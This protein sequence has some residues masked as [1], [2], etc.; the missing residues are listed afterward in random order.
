RCQVSVR[1]E[2]NMRIGV[3]TKSFAPDFELCT[4]LNRSVLVNSPDTVQHHII[5]PRSDL[6]LFS[7]LSSPRTHIRCEVD[8]LPRTFV[9]VPFI[10]LTINLA[11]P[12]PPIRGWILQQVV[13]LAAIAAS[14]D[15]AAL[16]V[17][18]DVEFIRPFTTETFIRDGNVRFFCK[19]N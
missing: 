12:F 4:S 18:S 2:R 3:I 16:V 11:R 13:K 10:N 6:E 7:R 5:V 15:D 1:D 19:P 9:R 17:D 8:L 14:E